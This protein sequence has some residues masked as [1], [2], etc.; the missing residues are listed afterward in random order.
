MSDQLMSPE[1][2]K[3]EY[4][5][6]IKELHINK[7]ELAK[8][9]K[10]NQK[11]QSELKNKNETINSLINQDFTELKSLHEKHDKIIKSLTESYDTN[12][13]NINNR[14]KLF[15]SSIQIK[16]QDSINTHYKLNN[17]KMVLLK[18]QNALLIN[19]IKETQNEIEQKE[20]R[21]R[22]LEQQY[23]IVSEKHIELVTKFKNLEYTKNTLETQLTELIAYNEN[24]VVIKIESDKKI[25]NLTIQKEILDTD[26]Y[27]TKHEL[28]KNTDIIKSLTNDMDNAK[29]SYHDI[30]NKYILLLNDNATKQNNIDEKTLEI[31][32]LSSKLNEIDK[33]KYI[34]G[35]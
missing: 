15:R 30:H 27:N 28:S 2:L 18:D 20:H 22:E 7:K 31:L 13:Q 32:S 34:T 16:L 6:K 21:V 11:L 17:D 12:I 10:I 8:T 29:N 9:I 24:Q 26:L 35:I 4:D 23:H 14:Y 25:I 1:L 3:M 5:K 19:K 33:K